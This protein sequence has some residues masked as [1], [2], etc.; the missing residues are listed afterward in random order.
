MTRLAVT[1]GIIVLWL[2]LPGPAASQEPGP[3]PQ[4][5]SARARD[6]TLAAGISAGESDA[7]PRRRRLVRWNEYEGPLFTFRFGA[8]FLVDYYNYSQDAASKEQFALSPGFKIRDSRLILGG[9]IKTKRR[10]TYQAGF[11]YDGYLDEWFVRQTGIMVAVPELWGHFFI[12]R[13]KEGPSLNRV[14][15]GYD[16]WTHE[17]FTFSDAAIPLLADGIKWLGY[18]PSRHLIWNLGVFTDFLSEGQSFSYF[19]HQVAG[20]VAWVPKVSDSVGTLLHIGVS[21][22]LGQPNNGF[23]QLR[24]RPEDS[25][26]PYF[27]DTGKFPATWANLVGVEVYYRPGPW[28]F[29]TEYYVEKANSVE[30]QNPLFHGGDVVATWLV[31][32]ETRSYNTV[33]GYFRGISP[34][35]TVFQGG[36]GAVELVLRF[37]YSD[38][39]GGN[40]QGGT[41]WRIT[42]MVNWH[43]SD[44][45]RLEFAYGY[46]RLDRFGLKGATHFFESR[47][48]VE[49]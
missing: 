33:G 4:D 3:A 7:E 31:T 15:V 11:M 27:L 6:S 32:G 12:G 5:T 46:G 36:P 25:K 21:F 8:G 45:V 19:D 13:S 9:R 48:Q 28:L 42:P 22:Q 47:L 38:L 26:A 35:R 14:M 43:L 40:L 37:S 10:I 17:R 1:G 18:I 24:S 49:F 34:G 44:N 20:R 16:G 23:L 41:F 39:N 2:M 29:G 30:A